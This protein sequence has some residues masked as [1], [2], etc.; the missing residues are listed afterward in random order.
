MRKASK[1]AGAECELWDLH[2]V[3][4][5]AVLEANGFDA[6]KT[7]YSVTGTQPS[8]RSQIVFVLKAKL[9]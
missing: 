1:E 9:F 6:R 4:D 2:T 3:L 8:R 7:C 5:E